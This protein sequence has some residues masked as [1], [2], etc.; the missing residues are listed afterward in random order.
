VLSHLTA[1]ALWDLQVPLG[2]QED[3]RV[4]LIVPA[5]S[6]AESR[7]D[8]RVHRSGLYDVEVTRVRSFDVTTPARTWRDLAAVLPPD[9][10]LAVTDQL[11][12]GRCTREELAAALELRP[13]GRGCARARA[14]LPLGD[15][16]AG[17]PMESVLRWRLHVA[18]LPAPV[19]QFGVWDGGRFA[20]QA[21]MVWEEAKLLVE[22]DGSVHRDPDVFVQDL[23]RQ[24]RLVAA[25]WTILRFSGA[26]VLTRCDEVVAE[27]SRALRAAA[28]PR[29]DA[30]L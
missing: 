1:A 16:K 28:R 26:D 18:G 14:V 22:F 24:N 5:G 9:A 15:E 11:L 6:A 13:S 4:D 12:A 10:L 21:D 20:G 3:R 23:R 7:S 2:D 8:R 17:S 25:G 27:I 30:P 19:L 29:P